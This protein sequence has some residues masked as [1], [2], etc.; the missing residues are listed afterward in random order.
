MRAKIAVIVSALLTL[1]LSWL[2]IS[3]DTPH[4]LP[5]ARRLRIGY[6]REPRNGGQRSR[7]AHGA[8]LH[9]P[10]SRYSHHRVV[11]NLRRYVTL[12]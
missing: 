4:D 2:W 11:S 7:H 6:R 12:S 9:E 5:E 10:S 8:T 3:L 1:G